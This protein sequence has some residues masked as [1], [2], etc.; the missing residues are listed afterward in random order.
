MRAADRVAAIDVVRGLA[1]FGVLVVNLT[2]EFRVS[3]FQQF[4]DNAPFDGSL[5]AVIGRFVSVFLESKA[6]AL[7]S[8]LFGVGMAIQYDRLARTGAPFYWLG[9]RLLALLGLGLVHLMLVWNGDILTEYAIVGLLAL[10]FLRLGTRYL[11][12]AAFA[13]LALY[14]AQPWPVPWPGNAALQTHVTL[15]NTVYATGSHAEILRFAF[16]EL[17][18]L[19]PLHLSIVPRTIGLFLLG[20]ALWRAELVTGTGRR[21][22]HVGVAAA[23]LLFAG[24]AGVFLPLELPAIARACMDKLAPILLAAGYG[25]TILWLMEARPVRAWLLKFAPLGRMAFTNYVMQSVVCAL[26][27]YGYGFG[28]FGRMPVA[29]AFALGIALYAAQLGMSTSW[30]R[31]FRFGPL[32]WLWRTLMYGKKQPMSKPAP[33]QDN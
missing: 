30:L 2:T 31:H 10:P 3:I 7:F 4:L 23:V 19:L 32:E 5:D 29:G 18:L 24:A 26:I 25:A 20:M 8:L 28:Q 22:V 12:F 17:G 21:N 16:H 11:F 1:L 33:V 9:R 6:I 14:V 15:A 27:F 13:F